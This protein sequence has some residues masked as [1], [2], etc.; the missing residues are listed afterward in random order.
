MVLWDEVLALPASPL[1]K[2]FVVVDQQELSA[3]GEIMNSARILEEG[4]WFCMRVIL[5]RP[6][7]YTICLPTNQSCPTL[8]LG[9]TFHP[10]WLYFKADVQIVPVSELYKVLR[11]V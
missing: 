10:F 6:H 7:L 2:L 1:C 11:F 8:L 9:F 4:A 5:F 3:N